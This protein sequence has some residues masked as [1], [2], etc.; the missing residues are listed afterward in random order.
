LSAVKRAEPAKAITREKPEKGLLQL[1]DDPNAKHRAYA[2][3]T[4][5][6]FNT[7]TLNQAFSALWMGGEMDSE[8][9]NRVLGSAAGAMM[10]IAPQDAIEGMLAAQLTA[11]HNA[12]MECYR[13]AMIPDQSLVAREANLNQANRLVRSYATLVAA[14]DKHRGKGQQTVRVEHVHVHSGGQ[15]VI[16]NV[17]HD[18]R[19]RD[20]EMAAE[21]VFTRGVSENGD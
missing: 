19:R 2:G 17:N 4:S 12:S 6:A 3:T 18:G 21:S 1:V 16:G 20:E 11:T 5:E 13:R 8:Q 9:H 14:L 15:A 7:A 10:N